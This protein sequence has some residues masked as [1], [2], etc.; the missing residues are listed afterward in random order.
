MLRLI[1]FRRGDEVGLGV[2]VLVER[3]V[4]R[5]FTVGPEITHERERP[6]WR[7]AGSDACP[8][9]VVSFAL[10]L[11]VKPH[12]V[13]AGLRIEENLGTLDHA[14]LERDAFVLPMVEI[15]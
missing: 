2:I 11:K 4:A 12:Y 7:F 14:T 13:Q 5:H 15:S 6:G 10:Q 8:R 1:V 9:R 3:H